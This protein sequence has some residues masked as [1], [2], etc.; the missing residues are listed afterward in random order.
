LGYSG[1][2]FAAAGAEYTP[3]QPNAFA[4][5][6][7]S[8]NQVQV[9]WNFN[10][11]T[12]GDK[13]VVKMDIDYQSRATIDYVPISKISH[14]IPNYYSAISSSPTLIGN[15]GSYAEE[16]ECEDASFRIDLDTIMNHS[17]NEYDLDNLMIYLTF[18]ATD[19]LTAYSLSDSNRIDEV[20]VVYSP[21]EVLVN[22]VLN[23]GNDQI[24][25]A[26]DQQIGS[27]LYIDPSGSNDSIIAHGNN[28]DNCD[29]YL[30]IENNQY[31]DIVGTGTP[32][33]GLHIE[34]SYSLLI[35]VGPSSVEEGGGGSSNNAN[36]RPTFGIDYQTFA[37]IVDGGLIINDETFT[38]SDNYWTHIPMQILTVGEVQNFTATSFSPKTLKVMEFLFGVPEVGAWD[39]AE[40][41]IALFFDYDGTIVDVQTNNIDDILID[42]NSMNYSSSKTLCTASDAT[43]VCDR[44]SIEIIFNESPLY[45]VIAVQAIDQKE[46]NN[47]LYFNDGIHVQ[48]ESLNPAVQMQILSAIPHQGLQ[49]VERIDKAED[50]WMT[51]DENEPVSLYYQNSFGTFLPLE[52]KETEKPMDNLSSIMNRDHSYFDLLVEV[53]QQRAQN[54]LDNLVIK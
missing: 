15:S 23:V 35:E 26:C 16:V 9:S 27:V 22:G 37:Q 36:A 8:T 12:A 53:E 33:Y 48:G 49:T 54:T 18:Y 4:S 44:V 47:I 7:N 45:E 30:Y 29:D 51:L 19:D 46:R 2:A 28:G 52:W 40:T 5:Y 3:T 39:E 42:F 20:F 14:Y 25:W 34:G 6:N 13:C 17:L 10:T 21:N 50:I 11:M 1:D 24:Q 41:S 31:V 38:V 43:P 32:S